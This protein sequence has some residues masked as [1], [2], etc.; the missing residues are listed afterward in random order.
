MDVTRLTLVPVFRSLVT[1][2]VPE[3]V[4]TAL[5]MFADRSVWLGRTYT[6]LIVTAMELPANRWE[7][8]FD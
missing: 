2:I 4:E 3:A 7:M 6:D 8:N 5:I 1:L